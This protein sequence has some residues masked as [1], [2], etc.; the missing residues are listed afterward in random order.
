[1]DNAVRHESRYFGRHR[2]YLWTCFRCAI[3]NSLWVIAM[4]Q[5]VALALLILE[6]HSDY[7]RFH[8]MLHLLG[9]HNYA[10]SLL[11]LST[12]YQSALLTT[13][14]VILRIFA[15][16]V[17]SS[18]WIQV[19]FSLLVIFPQALMAYVVRRSLRCTSLTGINLQGFE[20]IEMP[21]NMI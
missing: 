2:V 19:S 13:P 17:H 18:L 10:T 14:L 7:V 3:Q 21:P 16:L 4:M 15:S 20:H 9:V 12:A 8:G 1:M 6:T 11:M 5:P